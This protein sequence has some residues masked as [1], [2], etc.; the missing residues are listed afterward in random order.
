MNPVEQ[1]LKQ[2]YTDIRFE[3]YPN[4]K[5]KRIYLTGFI[6]PA[7]LR[8]TGIGTKFM[9]DLTR[10]ADEHGYKLTLSPSSSYGGNVNRLKDFYQRFGFV[11]NKGKNRDFSHR[12]DMYRD[13]KGGMNE[14]E[15]SDT[16]TSPSNSPAPERTKRGKANPTAN[17]G[18]YDYGTV[19]GKANPIT[20]TGNYEFDTN[21]GPANP[22][23]ED[24]KKNN[25]LEEAIINMKN[26]INLLG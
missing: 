17:T 4:E 25:R 20:N 7:S 12:E 26:L 10:L 1:E 14:D 13:P 6:V 22:I 19:R 24:G 23:S 18:A 3:L 9:E 2:K 11:M 16:G 15:S 8:N 21:R 5:F